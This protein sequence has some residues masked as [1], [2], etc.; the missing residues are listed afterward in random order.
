MHKTKQGIYASRTLCTNTNRKMNVN[1]NPENLMQ[2]IEQFALICP[3]IERVRCS[4]C[5][6]QTGKQ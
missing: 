1:L 4:C 5:A 2:Q 6:D 3:E